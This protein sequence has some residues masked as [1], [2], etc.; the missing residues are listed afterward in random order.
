MA[1]SPSSRIRHRHRRLRLVEQGQ[2]SPPLQP[3]EYTGFVTKDDDGEEE[4][5]RNWAELPLDALLAVLV[6][7]DL[8][9]V[10]LGAGHLCRPWRRAAREEPVLWRRIDIGRSSKLGMDY[11]F[12]PAVRAAVRRRVRWCE[13]F[14]AD[15]SNG[16]LDFF[17]VFLPD[18]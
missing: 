15:G 14:C 4:Q 7:L 2:L 3:D 18:V 8:A 10:L 5:T 11:R 17:F 9:D 12:Q 1:T 6:R 16:D 13:A